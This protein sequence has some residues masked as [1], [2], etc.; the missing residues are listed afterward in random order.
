MA[1]LIAR[2]A[3]VGAM[4]APL[5]VEMGSRIASEVTEMAML[6]RAPQKADRGV[7]RPRRS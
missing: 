4:S 7:S 2:L 5:T 3:A 1:K 6:S